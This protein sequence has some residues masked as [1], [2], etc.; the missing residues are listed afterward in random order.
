MKLPWH[1]HFRN[2]HAAVIIIDSYWMKPRWIWRRDFFFLSSSWQEPIVQLERSN[3]LK[4]VPLEICGWRHRLYTYDV[5]RADTEKHVTDLWGDLTLLFRTKVRW[6][7]ESTPG[8]L[9]WLYCRIQTENSVVYGAAVTWVR[10]VS[11][12]WA[13]YWIKFLT[14]SV[15]IWKQSWAKL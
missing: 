4:T 7:Y 14:L 10:P 2:T 6:G 15:R 9:W 1:V 12:G 13:E 8:M 3:E 5:L 11:L